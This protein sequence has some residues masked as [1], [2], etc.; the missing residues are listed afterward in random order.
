MLIANYPA[1]STEALHHLGTVEPTKAACGIILTGRWPH[2]EGNNPGHW[3]MIL[4]AL[5]A[6]GRRCCPECLDQ[7]VHL[8]TGV[9]GRTTRDEWREAETA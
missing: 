4:L 5:A 8:A 1:V 7:A 3:S 9:D 6:T 2:P